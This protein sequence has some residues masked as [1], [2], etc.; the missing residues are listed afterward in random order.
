MSQAPSVGRVAAGQC[1]RLSCV[2]WRTYTRLLHAIGDRRD[3]RLTYVRGELEI[4]SPRLEHDDDSDFLG[5]L[6]RTLTEELG[7][8]VKGGGSVTIHLRRKKRGLEPDRCYWIV[9]AARMAGR[10][11]LDLRRD[12][13]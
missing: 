3:V 1:L 2:D 4:M 13:P 5:I 11:E 8:P 7:L 12:P 9:N 10:R 6:I